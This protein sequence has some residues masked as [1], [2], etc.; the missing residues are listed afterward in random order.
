MEKVIPFQDKLELALIDAEDCEGFRWN[1]IPEE[2]KAQ[3]AIR[4]F[5]G[6]PLAGDK[7]RQDEILS[8]MVDES[9]LTVKDQLDLGIIDENFLVNYYNENIDNENLA[10][11]REQYNR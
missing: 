10:S 7:G 4:L 5:L 2:L 11:I 6:T 3:V 1:Q 8:K 9:V